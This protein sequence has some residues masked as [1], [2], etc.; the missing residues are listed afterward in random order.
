MNVWKDRQKRRY[1]IAISLIVLLTVGSYLTVRTLIAA[2]DGNAAQINV[3]GRQRMLSQRIA[4]YALIY[5]TADTEQQRAEAEANLREAVDLFE[6]SHQ[7]LINGG[8]VNGFQ[9][10]SSISLPGNPSA[11]IND[12]Y[13]QVPGL[14]DPQVRNYVEATRSL[15]EAPEE[16]LTL[17]NPDLQYILIQGPDRLLNSLNTVVSTHQAESDALTSL[18]ATAELAILV[19]I[20]SAIAFV[21][22]VLLRPTLIETA[23]QRQSL[24]ETNNQLTQQTQQLNAQA[25]GLSL[26]TEVSTSIGRIRDLDELLQSAVDLIRER[27]DLYYVQVYLADAAGRTLSLQTGTGTAGEEL[28]KRGHRL[29]I[30]PGSINGLAGRDKRPII[31]ENTQESPELF[32]PNPLLP[33]TRTEMA[34]PMVV[35]NRLVGVLDLQND[36]AFSL[37]RRDLPAFEVLASEL[38]IAI[39]NANLFTQVVQTQADFE[40]QARRLA[41]SNWQAYLDNVEDGERLRYTYSMES[42]GLGNTVDTDHTI[43]NALFTAPI[44]VVNEQI[45]VLQIEADASYQ[46]DHDDTEFVKA[47]AA[48]VGQQVENLRLIEQ[49]ELY[50]AEA[51]QALRRLTRESWQTYI[52]EQESLADGYRFN[53]HDTGPL[54]AERLEESAE[55]KTS[56]GQTLT[57]ELTVRGEPIGELELVVPETLPEHQAIL[58]AVTVSLSN[59]IENLRLAQQT[60]MALGEAQL[61][62][63]ELAIINSTVATVTRAPDVGEGLEEILDPLLL[64]LGVRQARIAL[65]NE[66]QT[67]LE[68]TAERYDFDTTDSALGVTL[69][70]RGNA[71]MDEIVREQRV[72]WIADTVTDPRLEGYRDTILAQQVRAMAIIPI[73]IENQVIGTLGIDCLHD[74]PL[75]TTSQIELAETIM[76]QTGTAIQNLQLSARAQKRAE[77]L[78]M[79][80]NVGRAFAQQL[81][82][83]QLLDEML[84][85]VEQVFRFDSFFVGL[86]DQEANHLTLP[87]TYDSGQRLYDMPPVSLVEG[88]YSQRIVNSRTPM[89]VHLTS[90]EHAELAQS[91]TNLVGDHS[92]VTASMIFVPMLIAGDLLGIISV[93]SNEFNQYDQNDVNV[94]SGIANSFVIAWQNT[95]LYQQAERR[96][97][98]ERLVNEIGQ[99]I[100]GTATME[101]AI[102]TTLRELG[103]A[104]KARTSRVKLLDAEADDDWQPGQTRPLTGELARRNPGPSNGTNGHHTS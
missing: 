9:G 65:I 52:D 70:L 6:E 91:G 21:G 92:Q 77:E 54:S 64:I 28:A 25:R 45:G 13:Y 43:H 104:L 56:R 95:Q 27:F 76:L 26:A 32:R 85:Q 36:K 69:P 71:L 1:I 48:Q 87:L 72:V 22:L 73:I 57:N 50:R 19:I 78:T 18:L 99:K 29:P 39:E 5:T 35:G 101:S 60:E 14:V 75:L 12:L 89:L 97:K 79:L 44:E 66:T 15:L 7:R 37:K 51:E 41:R 8:V 24:L 31:V 42:P 82:P 16:A 83:T 53:G 100:Q 80:N 17:E 46:W 20:L 63:E 10:S 67:Q 84:N 11:A 34:I 102:E 59:H 103:N 47:I 86:L 74:D 90:A 93:Q 98:R 81:D 30:G 88:T 55:D 40:T 61:R 62:S 68:I 58:E 96:A 2:N 4:L 23:Q 38:A 94:L 3:S 33:E 49:A